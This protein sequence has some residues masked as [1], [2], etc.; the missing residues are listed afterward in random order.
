MKKVLFACI[1]VLLFGVFSV[2]AQNAP[3]TLL[4]LCSTFSD[5]FS[6][7]S[8]KHAPKNAQEVIENMCTS[9][10]ALGTW[11]LYTKDDIV[12]SM[13]LARDSLFLY[14]V[15]S[16]VVKT[17]AQLALIPE[18]FNQKFSPDLMFIKDEALSSWKKTSNCPDKKGSFN[19]CDLSVYLPDL[20][21][22]I[23]DNYFSVK[24]SKVYGLKNIADSLDKQIAQFSL[25]Y[26][27]PLAN[28]CD[29][30]SNLYPKTCKFLTK[31]ME[32]AKKL[33]TV[34]RWFKNITLFDFGVLK[35]DKNIVCPSLVSQVYSLD[36]YDL[37]YC[38]LY[39][40]SSTSMTHFTNLVY[41]ELFWYRILIAYYASYA[42]ANPDTFLQNTSYQDQTPEQKKAV[43]FQ[44]VEDI[45]T[46]SQR[47]QLGIE[48]AFKILRE[49]RNTFPLHIGFMMYQEDVYRFMKKLG[50]IYTPFVT[51]HDKLINVQ[52]K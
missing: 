36:S 8:V 1:S 30:T 51:L 47:A 26:F 22:I 50:K 5:N 12:Q 13:Y 45:S 19:N 31:Y 4:P 25:D 10:F 49:R 44:K 43:M 7:V 23:M 42:R 52:K 2:H 41:N 35:P 28:I 6:L 40:E 24:Q 15:C 37:L 14:E 39:D 34:K 46:Q 20:F 21:S 18:Y 33:L 16:Q 32:R 11:C 29:S 38:G 9:L 3:S 27:P 17:P 48:L